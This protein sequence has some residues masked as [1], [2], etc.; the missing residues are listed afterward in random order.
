MKKILFL[1]S[2]FCFATPVKGET[3]AETALRGA[4]LDGDAPAI[5]GVRNLYVANGGEIDLLKDVYVSDAGGFRPTLIARSE[6]E[7]TLQ[8]GV[9]KI[10]YAA[11]DKAGARTEAAANLHV[12]RP[13]SSG[14]LDAELAPILAKIIT[15]DMS[16]E[17]KARAIWTWTRTNIRYAGVSDKS[18]VY[19][20][21]AAG[22]RGGRGDCFTFHSISSCLLSLAG[23]DNIGIENWV[24][25]S[26]NHSWSMIN[27]GTGWY[28]FDA[29]PNAPA[30]GEGFMFDEE[31]RNRFITKL[32]KT[33]YQ[34]DLSA[35][36]LIAN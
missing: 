26:L 20:A 29:T 7:N 18:S 28:F 17:E 13:S 3:L 1:I 5:F 22:L 19:A 27:V 31:S 2:V 14:E 6:N 12:G 11:I 25:G 8:T 24:D 35:F 34:K 4:F 23:I 15:E 16:A 36:P 32:G 30:A 10:F 33:F 9:Y 21:A